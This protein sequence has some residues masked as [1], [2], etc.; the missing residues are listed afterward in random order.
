[1]Q[2]DDN[3]LVLPAT[4]LPALRSQAQVFAFSYGICAGIR[5]FLFS[6]LSTRLM[7][8]L[9]WVMRETSPLQ[10]QM[11]ICPV[12]HHY[13]AKQAPVTAK[14]AP[15]TDSQTKFCQ[16]KSTCLLLMRA[17]AKFLMP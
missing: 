6:I 5:G 10:M 7:E 9:R 2:G 4:L 1:V 13:I 8:Q 16:L 3:I 15:V 14:Q 17:V 12:A 11:H